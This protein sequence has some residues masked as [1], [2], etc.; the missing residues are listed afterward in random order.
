[1]KLFFINSYTKYLFI[2]SSQFRDLFGGFFVFSLLLQ[3]NTAQVS[4][5]LD[6]LICFRHVQ[7]YHFPQKVFPFFIFGAGLFFNWVIDQLAQ[8]DRIVEVFLHF[9]D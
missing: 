5:H 3:R 1:M 9:L 8:L 6:F 2:C 4:Q 7:I